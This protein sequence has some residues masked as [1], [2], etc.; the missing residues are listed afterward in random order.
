MGIPSVVLTTGKKS[1][2]N[3]PSD[4]LE[5]IHPPSLAL[6]TQFAFLLAYKL[7]NQ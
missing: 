6:R 4:E 3:T 7:A 5:T 1:Y 2:S